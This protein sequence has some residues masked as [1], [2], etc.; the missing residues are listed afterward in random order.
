VAGLLTAEIEAQALVHGWGQ[1]MG[2]SAWFLRP[3]PAAPLRTRISVLRDKGRISIIDNML[4]SEDEDDPTAMV[5]V[6]LAKPREVDVPGFQSPAHTVRD[7]AAAPL[8]I[9]RMKIRAGFLDAIEMR[10][11]GGIT[12][13]RVKEEVITGAGPLAQLLVPADLAHG[14]NRPVFNVVADPNPN[15]SVHLIS[16]PRGEWIGLEAETLWQPERG[17]GVGGARIHDAF[18]AIGWVSMAVALTPFPKEVP[19]AA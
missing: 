14:L 3:T 5:R 9:R 12:W 8:S 6:T 17:V 18:G 16:A 15:L 19:A 4:W 11:D 10:T 1:A 2:V 13:F 7:P